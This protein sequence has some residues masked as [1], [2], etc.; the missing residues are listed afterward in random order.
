[1][2]FKAGLE[3]P[4]WYVEPESMKVLKEHYLPQGQV[5]IKVSNEGRKDNTM[6]RTFAW[7]ATDLG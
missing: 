4:K 7:H 1:M 6:D 5:N 3:G 2:A